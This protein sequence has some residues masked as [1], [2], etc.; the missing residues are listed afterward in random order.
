MG[1]VPGA[2]I[3]DSGPWSEVA[4]QLKYITEIRQIP[5]CLKLKKGF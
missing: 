1:V 4:V 2:Q 3:S 5:A